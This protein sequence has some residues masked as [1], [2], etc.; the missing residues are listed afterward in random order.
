MTAASFGSQVL[1]ADQEARFFQ[2]DPPTCI[3]GD[4]ACLRP[5]GALDGEVLEV[6]TRLSVADDGTRY[7]IEEDTLRVFTPLLDTVF[8]LESPGR[9]VAVVPAGQSGLALAANGQVLLLQMPRCKG[10]TLRL[11]GVPTG[12]RQCFRWRYGVDLDD[13]PPAVID[14]NTLAVNGARRLHAVAEGTDSW[15]SPIGSVG[16]VLVG[17]D[18]LLYTLAVDTEGEA[19]LAVKAV[20]P[21]K[22]TVQWA[23]PLPFAPP[24]A[25]A[26]A[27]GELAT[28]VVIPETA[29]LDTRGAWIVAGFDQHVALVAVQ[30]SAEGS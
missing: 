8:E 24:T 14:E 19:A 17:S 29:V 10:A 26:A 15:K 11:P 6:G 7:L 23:V 30:A 5:A 22:G 2:V 9:I 28:D 4:P 21:G 16:A 1:V 18:G 25:P 12:S 20:H 27:E 3:Q 13:A